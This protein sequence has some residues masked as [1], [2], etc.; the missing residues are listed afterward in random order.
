MALW[1]LLGMAVFAGICWGVASVFA[2]HGEQRVELEYQ[3]DQ[4]GDRGRRQLPALRHADHVE[5]LGHRDVLDASAY[6]GRRRSIAKI[7]K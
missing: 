5:H 4:G 3:A 2:S 1:I 6:R 7:M